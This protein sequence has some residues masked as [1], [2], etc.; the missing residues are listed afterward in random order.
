MP[1][2]LKNFGSTESEHKKK[3][4]EYI[5]NA[6]AGW[7]EVTRYIKSIDPYRHPITI[8]PTNYGHDMIDDISLIDID[9]LQTGHS[10]HNSLANTLDMLKISLTHTPKMPVLVGEVCYEGIMEAS[11][12]EIQRFLFW[13]CILSGAAGHT[14]GANGIWQVNTNEKPFGPSPHG[15]SWGDIS[16]QEAYKLPGSNQLGIGKKLLERYPW[17]Q[18]EPHQEWAEPHGSEENRFRPYV[19]GIPEKVR[20]VYIPSNIGE[21]LS[22]VKMV[23]PNIRYQAFYFDPKNGREYNLGIVVSDKDG[24]WRPPKPPIFQDWVLVLEN[25][26]N[27]V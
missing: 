6:R 17:W 3:R 21:G 23:E 10:S 20:I 5:A 25:I 24:N 15:M 19:A 13:T 1:Y 14:Y 7:T 9:M 26:G 27:E 16:W 12:Q 2:Y 11:R 4:E 18:F 8:H 22:L